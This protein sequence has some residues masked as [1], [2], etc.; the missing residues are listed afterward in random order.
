VRWEVAGEVDSARFCFHR[1][2]DVL[3]TCAE[4]DDARGR[5]VVSSR[6]FV[7]GAYTGVLYAT[8]PGGQGVS[9]PLALSITGGSPTEGGC[10]TGGGAVGVLACAAALAAVGG[11]RR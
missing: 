10:A 2:D 1:D 6:G 9:A 7:A 3:E 11:R 8:G 5:Q 4:L